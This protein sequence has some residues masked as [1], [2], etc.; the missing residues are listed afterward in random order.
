MPAPTLPPTANPRRGASL[1]VTLGALIVALLTLVVCGAVAIWL[2]VRARTREATARGLAAV[3]T[4]QIER[5]VRERVRLAERSLESLSAE[6][7]AGRLPV[8]DP[9]ALAARLRERLAGDARLEWLGFVT[10]D[11][12]GAEAVSAPGGACLSVHAGAGQPLVAERHAADGSVTPATTRLGALAD[13]QQAPWYALGLSARGPAWTPIYPRRLDGAPGRACALAARREGALVGVA[14]AG[15]SAAFAGPF[16]AELWQGRRGLV[17]LYNPATQ[18]VGASSAGG[19]APGLTQ[20]L[21][22][23]VRAGLA[24]GA[25]ASPR[26]PGTT[27]LTHDGRDHVVGF[28]RL[29]GDVSL[30]SVATIV[31]PEDDLVGH[32]GPLSLAGLGLLALLAA[33]GVVA[34]LWISARVAAPLRRL[35]DDLGRVAV[36]DLGGARPEA[37]RIAEVAVLSDAAE[38]M[39][40]SLRSF[41]RYV[42]TDLVRQL[43]AAGQEARLGGELRTLTLF[44]S[45]VAGFT[46]EAERLPPTEL[47]AALGGYLEVVVQALRR[48]GATVDKF[49]GDGVVAFFN[50]PAADPDHAASACRAALAVQAA[51]AQARERWAGEGRPLFPTR[52]GLN[53]AEV[54]VGNLG[55]S[56]RF[57]YTV[58]GDGVNLA[59]RLE[60]LNK[61]YGTS[62]LASRPT[63]EAAGPG[64]RWR[65]VDRVAV[66]GRSAEDDVFEL[67]GEEGGPAV[68]PGAGKD[69]D[70]SPAS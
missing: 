12:A 55:T 47:V 3:V 7:A 49:V 21:A 6:A 52:I 48:A 45:D 46:S 18:R 36:F 60:A 5:E 25:G 13:L 1:R 62:I 63:R 32:F 41:A 8:Q 28:A 17:A 65:H 38:R 68:R 34:A 4:Q 40:S 30:P 37:T 61:V 23:V 22:E 57:A 56:E 69:D 58:I 39:K 16:L 43:L 29:G 19:D 15:F 67:L 70:A 11:G 24:A 51:L 64:F 54:V 66:R 20:A 42:P 33:L 10:P 9:A 35:A 50:A 2:A 27:T 59:A 53:T 31:V 14:V 26:E 44:F